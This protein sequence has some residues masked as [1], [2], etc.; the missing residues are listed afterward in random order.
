[1][2]DAIND[3]LMRINESYQAQVRFVSDASHELRTP[4]AVIQGYAN[5]LD[6]WESQMKRP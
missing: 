3:L 6:R 5:M 1:L 2:A 4:I